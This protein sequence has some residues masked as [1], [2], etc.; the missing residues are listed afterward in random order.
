MNTKEIKK[1]KIE[2]KIENEHIGQIISIKNTQNGNSYNVTHKD[3]EFHCDCHF[4]T[5]HWNDGKIC[6]HIIRAIQFLNDGGCLHNMG[7]VRCGDREYS[8]DKRHGIETI[9]IYFCKECATK[10]SKNYKN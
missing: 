8:F 10:K 5:I 4:G 2:S 3:N 7:S 6:K 1:L 9:N